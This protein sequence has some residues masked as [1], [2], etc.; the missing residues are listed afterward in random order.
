LVFGVGNGFAAMPTSLNVAIYPYVPRPDQFKSV[1]TA[2]WKKIQPNVS[3]I[4]VTGW[5]GGYKKDPDQSYDVF[6]F[7]ALYYDYFV[8]KNYLTPLTGQIAHLDD[9]LNY[10]LI[11]VTN[12]KTGAIYAIPQLGCGD[13]L[14]YR[15]DDA[16]LAKASTISELVSAI[17]SCTYYCLT[18]QINANSGLLVDFSSVITDAS[19]YIVSLSETTNKFPVPLPYNSNQIDRT[20]ANNIQ[21][22]VS[23]ASFSNALAGSYTDYQRAIW[24]NQ[25]YGRAYVGFMESLSQIDSSKL[26]NIAFKP[27]PWS[28]NPSGAKKPLFYS[29]VIGVNTTTTTRGTTRL[30]IQLAN[31][32]ASSNVITQCFDS[33]GASVPQ[34]LLPVRP[35]V[36]HVLGAKYPLYK[37]MYTMVQQVN[38]IFFNLGPDAKNWLSTIKLSMQ[39]MVLAN[40][41]C[42]CDKDAGTISNNADAQ[43]KCPTTCSNYGGWNGQWTN[44]SPGVSVCGCNCGASK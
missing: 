19:D 36:Y 14:F 16:A 32:M 9:F 2:E 20:T 28:D 24:F 15:K 35:T 8:S 30:A 13:F 25:G 5:D 27:F 10:A 21:N 34:Y 7:D 23:M 40:P 41:K 1:I 22:I 6:V 11:G 29:D 17:G 38:P 4:F 3:L 26:N 44:T 12:S 18:P 37:D 39:S 33:S 31:L 43:Q 42:Y